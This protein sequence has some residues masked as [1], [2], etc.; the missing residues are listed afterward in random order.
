MNFSQLLCGFVVG[1]LVDFC[2]IVF[3]EVMNIGIDFDLKMKNFLMLVM[4]NVYLECFGCCFCEMIESK[5]ELVCCEIV[6]WFVQYGL[7]GQLCIGN[8][9]MSQLYVVF[10]FFLKVLVVKID[11]SCLLFELLIVLNMFDELQ[12][13]VVD[14]VKKFDKVLFDQIGVNLNSVFVNVDKLFKQ[15]DMQVVLEVCDMLLVVKQIFLIVEVMLQQDLLLQFDVCGVL[16][17]FMCML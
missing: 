5:G 17:E 15:F 2:G 1:V 9:L 7:C 8:L 14:I 4:I 13:Q 12:L 16:K 6:E 11:M 10:D 3:G